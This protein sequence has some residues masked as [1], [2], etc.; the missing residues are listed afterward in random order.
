VGLWFSAINVQYRDIRYVIP[1][2]VQFWFFATPVVY[3]STLLPKSWKLIYGLNPMVGVIEGFRW[4]LLGTDPPRMLIVVSAMA[5]L[6]I[7]ISGAF[8]FRYMEKIFAD[9]V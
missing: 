6:F 7:L 1:F 4:S 8:Y 3:P 5:V 2:L 9:V